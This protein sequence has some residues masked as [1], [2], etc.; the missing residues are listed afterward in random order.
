MAEKLT[1]D[2]GVKEYELNGAAKVY[3]NPT[4]T[5]F[6]ERVYNAFTSLESKQEDFKKEV[7]SV[8]DDSDK[9]F[10]YAK[11]RDIEMRE[12]VDELLGEGV[13]DAVFTDPQGRSI[14]CYALAGGIPVWMNLMFGIA[15]TISDAFT[16][17]EKKKDPRLQ[18]L[19]GKYAKMA[20]KYKN[21]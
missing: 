12:I 5:S 15:E 20:K 17:E 13:S 11:K 1:F 21:K 8:K 14:N 18:K 9:M 16:A 7:D 2:T 3:F 4:D 19:S 6:V 10:S